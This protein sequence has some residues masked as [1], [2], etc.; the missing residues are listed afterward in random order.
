[1]LRNH[2]PVYYV[3][4][5]DV[6][7]LSRYA[8][9]QRVSR[10]WHSFSS[11]PS[12]DLDD[13]ANII[14]PG[15]FIDVDPP[16][17]DV[18]RGLLRSAFSAK[19]VTAGLGP[20]VASICDQLIRN[21]AE[22]REVDLAAALAW[23]LPVATL[24]HLMG[25]PPQDVD[26]LVPLLQAIVAR[27]PGSLHAPP[28]ALAAYEVMTEYLVDQIH[29]RE[30]HAQA[31][32]LGLIVEGTRAGTVRSGEILGLCFL[33]CQAGTSTTAGLISNALAILYDH[34][35]QR[36]SLAREPAL[37]AAGIEEILR[38]EAPVQYLARRAV[39][40]VLVHDV[41]IPDGDRVVLL[42]GAANRDE[43]RFQNSEVLD[44]TREP[45]RH[46]GFGE[47]IHSCLGGPLARL[48]SRILLERFLGRFPDYELVGEGVRSTE[49]TTRGFFQLPAYLG[50]PS[51]R[52]P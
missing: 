41:R 43:R 16:R 21:V 26:A 12:V 45:R 48:E 33:M 52:G 30:R 28:S 32:V 40:E 25:F 23:P 42:Y 36:R 15:S 49:H 13:T 22:D 46:L 47:G 5:R 3:V 20:S 4:E 18:L 29:D 51:H 6:W 37:L 19:T 2:H 8:D 14:G 35:D 38:F 39:R 44:L 11:A 10:D 7:V 1:M 9:V 31:D 17:H 50:P 34:P 27:Q 24:C